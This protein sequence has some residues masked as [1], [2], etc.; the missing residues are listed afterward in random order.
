MHTPLIEL[1]HAGK[2]YLDQTYTFS[3]NKGSLLLITGENGK[4]KTTLIQLI[5]GFIQTDSGFVRTKKM[6]MGYL[7][8]KTML[9]LFVKVNRYLETMARIK[10]T[11]VDYR[12]ILELNVPLN[13]G[14][15][16]LSKGNQQKLAI[17][18]TLMGCPDLVI[19]DE[20]LSGLDDESKQALFQLI[21]AKKNEQMSFII[22]THQP[23]F[24]MS[25]ADAHLAL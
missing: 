21:K 5:L 22:T 10:K 17:I 3:M 4:G 6:K 12:L 13:K 15:H 8:E 25:L 19:L 18:S 24:F 14:I 1:Y 23:S 11:E 7:P 16:E 9:P 2:R 20:P